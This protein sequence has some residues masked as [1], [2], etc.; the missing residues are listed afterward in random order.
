MKFDLTEMIKI[1]EDLNKTIYETQKIDW[2]TI[3]NQSHLC[4]VIE[5][6]ELCN[7]TRCFNYWSKK[8]RSSDD[9]ILEEFADVLCF[10]VTEIIPLGIKIIEINESIKQENQLSLTRRFHQLILNYAELSIDNPNTYKR[11]TEDLFNLGYAL[12][13]SLSQIWEAYLK[14]V[15]KNYK[16]QED[17]KTK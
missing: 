4:I 12:G 8:T 1:Q 6:M 13:Y 10:L 11:F 16:V 3:K 2:S 5:L 9:V 14:K 17:F 7:E 15:Q